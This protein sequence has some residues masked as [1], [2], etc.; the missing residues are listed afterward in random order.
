MVVHNPIIPELERGGP[1]VQG[2]PQLQSEFEDNPGY[3]RLSPKQKQRNKSFQPPNK[4]EHTSTSKTP[5]V[6]DKAI[7]LM[8]SIKP[9]AIPLRPRLRKWL[10]LTV[11]QR[12]GEAA[13]GPSSGQ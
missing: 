2:Q 8:H 10:C 9:T 7:E 13:V 1:E 5:S 11:A 3:I 12:W 6:V 4:S